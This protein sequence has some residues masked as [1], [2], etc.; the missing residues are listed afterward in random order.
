MV[1][2]WILSSTLWDPWQA[3]SGSQST[4]LARRFD[5]FPDAEIDDGKDEHDAESKLPADAPQVLE[6]LGPVDL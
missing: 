5:A 4:H 2:L 6:T 3:W 1:Q